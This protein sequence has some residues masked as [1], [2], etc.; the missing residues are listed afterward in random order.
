MYINWIIINN[1]KTNFLIKFIWFKNI[2]SYALYAFRDLYNL[3][4]SCNIYN[5]FT[6]Y[7]LYT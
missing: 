7:T 4:N 2:I 6:S 3:Y 1:Q 5:S